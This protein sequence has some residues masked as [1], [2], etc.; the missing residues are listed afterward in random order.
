MVGPGSRR[1]AVGAHKRKLY[2]A[3][4][5]APRRQP[6]HEVGA[7]GRLVANRSGTKL[8]PDFQAGTCEPSQPGFI[9][10]PRNDGFV[11]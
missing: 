10:C 1:A 5:D 11:H 7:D 2:E 3:Q 8:C 6:A 9:R 4:F